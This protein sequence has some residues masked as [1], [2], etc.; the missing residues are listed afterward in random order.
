[1]LKTGIRPRHAKIGLQKITFGETNKD[2]AVTR[3][4]GILTVRGHVTQENVV[5]LAVVHVLIDMTLDVR[6]VL[7]VRLVMEVDV[8]RHHRHR[9]HRRLELQ[10]I[11]VGQE[12]TSRHQ[13]V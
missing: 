2:I 1:V 4:T 5:E 8:G 12:H 11:N 3:I 7:L 9:R 6:T 10:S 13:I